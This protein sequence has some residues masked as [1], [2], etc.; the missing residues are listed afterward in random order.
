MKLVLSSVANGC[1]HGKLIEVGRNSSKNIDIPG[2]LLY[3]RTGSVPHLTHDTLSLIEGVPEPVHLTLST[4]AE[5]HEV[6]EEYK[7]G[8][9]KFIGMPESVLYCSLHD[10]ASPCPSGYNTNKTVSI[11]GGGGRIE[12]TLSKFM[13]M[14][15]AFKPHW[16]QSM[17]DGEPLPPG[18]SRKRV[19][20][21]VDRTLAFLDGCLKEHQSS[22]VLKNSEILGVIEGGDVL[23][24][25][26]RS[27]RETIKRPVGG[28]LLDGF[29]GEDMPDNSKLNLI[30]SV[31]GELPE[32]KPRLIHGIGKPDEVLECI[33]RGVDLFEGFFPY[34]MTEQGRALTFNFKY[35]VD[36]EAEV[37]ERN[38]CGDN[39][40]SNQASD[41]G[42]KAVPFTTDLRSEQYRADF[43][44]LLEDCSCYC[45]KNHTRA[46]LY[47]LLITNELL[48][49]VLLMIHNQHHYFGF[50]QSIRDALRDNKMHQLKE[51]ITK[52]KL[53]Q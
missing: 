5:H 8:I 23:E 50:F 51:L 43:R 48:A 32:D 33:S 2:C 11:W 26:L 53:Q 14:Q 25:R 49:G 4:L 13:A 29:Q 9:G 31:T 6:L 34:L 45:C 10:P 12:I 47:H 15:Q 44:P 39:K 21:S 19:K 3:T 52:Q 1:R 27:V 38:G 18:T 40:I 42:G 17:A 28:F 24:E 35:K 46:Y 7:E 41:S 16:Y 22:E 37:L 36:P 30:A 20:K